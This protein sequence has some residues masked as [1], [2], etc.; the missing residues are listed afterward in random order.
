MLSIRLFRTG[1]TNQPFFRLV[2]TDKRNAPKGGRFLEVLG[3]LDPRTKTNQL[4]AER[5]KYWI[6]MGAKPSD[7]VHNLLVSNK[8]ITGPK[9]AVH[10][11]AKKKEAK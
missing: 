5:I 4:K 1:K 10:A 8:V 3:S 6:S 11:K 7:T 9:K 2:V